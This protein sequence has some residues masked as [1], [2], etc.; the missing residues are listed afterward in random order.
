MTSDGIR[1]EKGHP[2]PLGATPYGKGINFSL[3]APK[4]HGAAITLYNCDDETVIGTFSLNRSN[5]TH[6]VWHILIE[7]L[8]ESFD[9]SW[10]LEGPQEGPRDLP[11]DPERSVLDPFARE[12]NTPPVWGDH[13]RILAK[14]VRARY[15]PAETF[16]WQSV[17]KPVIPHEQLVI[18][19]MHVRSFTIDESSQCKSPGTYLG[20]VEKI[21]YLQE[22]GVNAIE[23]MPVYEFDER[24][25]ENIDPI[26]NKK[27]C[28]YWGYSTI[29]FFCPMKRF[30][31]SQERQG[32]I[33]EFK[34]MVRELHK[35]GIEVILDVV[36]NHTAEGHPDP[37]FSF[38]GIDNPG[39]YLVDGEGKDMNFSGTGNTFASNTPEG[40]ELI[41]SSL[42][43]WVNE[44]HIDGFRFDLASISTRGE[45]GTVLES[46]PL[47]IAIARDP[48]LR[49]VK[50]IAE[51]WDAAGLYQLGEFPKWGP[52]C[53]WNGR[54]R[55]SV[56]RFIKGTDDYAGMFATAL[57]GSQDLYGKYP[58]GSQH[59][60]NFVTCHDGFT[61]RDLVSYQ[62]KHNLRNAEDN[63]D[64]NNQNDSWNC[65][66][67][68]ETDDPSVQALRERQMRNFHLALMLAQGIPMIL[69]GDEYGHTREGNNNTWCHDDELNWFNWNAQHDNP[70]LFRFYR[71]LILFRKKH[72]L[73]A[74]KP[75][76][77]DKDITWLGSHHEAPDWGKDCRFVAAILKDS[78]GEPK[79]YFAFN[80]FSGPVPVSLPEPPESKKWHR[81]V[82]TGLAAPADFSDPPQPLND[83]HY[84]MQPYSSLLLEIH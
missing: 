33:R 66:A 58:L 44:M 21:P 39:Y 61:L 38:K 83:L 68:G 47:L 82:D 22:L 69:M 54:F 6:N 3:R 29:N 73:L 23:L 34:T 75:A 72:P 15:T 17:P 55:D 2:F 24:S 9:Y 27:L 31:G 50:L 70:S 46:P 64:G 35:A 74:R 13:E 78:Y 51:G 8:P 63:R 52:W 49:S 45:N 60:I 53:E 81:I 18:Y 65:G 14:P 10:Y 42:R 59:S 19:E 11:F 43:Y 28:N 30:A 32:A 71:E 16:D 77:T 41:L 40:Q 80:A 56:R 4:A 36:Y 48:H 26:K 12:L 5:K 37:I 1:A 20:I 79:L 67:E 25:Y 7:G 76:F 62:D 84:T 57:S